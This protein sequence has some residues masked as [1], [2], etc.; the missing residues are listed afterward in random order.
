M[1]LKLRTEN[2]DFTL[3]PDLVQPESNLDTLLFIIEGTANVPIHSINQLMFG[4]PPKKLKPTPQNRETSLAELSIKNGDVLTVKSGNSEN[5]G[6][7]GG[8]PVRSSQNGLKTPPR[9]RSSEDQDYKP[10]SPVVVSE[11]RRNTPSRSNNTSKPTTIPLTSTSLSPQTNITAL[12]FEVPADN[13]CLFYSIYYLLHGELNKDQARTYRSIVSNK[14][15]TNSTGIPDFHPESMLGKPSDEYCAWI[16]SDDSWGGAIELSILSN[17]FKICVQAVDVK[18]C[19]IHRFPADG[20]FQD[21]TVFVLYDG[22]HYDPLY[23]DLFS[24]KSTTFDFRTTAEINGVKAECGEKVKFSARIEKSM[25]EVAKIL[26]AARQY[27]DTANFKIRCGNCGT[28]L[29]SEKEAMNHAE[30]TGHTNFQEIK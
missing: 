13:T 6:P 15:L 17:H 5:G 23:L 21:K 19:R 30:S 1:R 7:L 26:Q 2:G 14:I 20:R 18:T 22:I 25:V 11:K 29:V 4:Y 9:K 8:G 16:Q 28:Q 12:R 10:A 27:T 3:A 24:S